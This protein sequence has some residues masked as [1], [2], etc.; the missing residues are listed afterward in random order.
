MKQKLILY[1]LLSVWMPV[2]LTGCFYEHPSLTEDGEWGT[3]PTAVTVMANFCLHLPM[4]AGTSETVFLPEET[5]GYRQ[6]VIVEAYLNRQLVA[7]EV[8]Y[9]AIDRNVSDVTIPV[10]MELH[11]RNYQLAVWVDYI[12]TDTVADLYYDTHTGGS[13]MHVIGNGSY[14]GNSA[15][16]DVFC[17]CQELDLTPYAEQ[18]NVSVPFD[19]TLAR[20]VARYELV[21]NDVAQFL[22]RIE[23]SEIP[24]DEFT[25]RLIYTGYVPTGYNV[26]DGLPRQ[27]LMYIEYDKTFRASDLETGTDYVLAFDYVFPPEGDKSL[28]ARLEIL[29][30]EE[31]IAATNFNLSLSP[32]EAKTLIHA[33]LTAS[34]DGG[35]V[36]DPDY[37]GEVDIDVP[38]IIDTV[39]DK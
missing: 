20:P 33:F 12:R 11:A 38:G 27:S 2:F 19:M 4:D 3:D 17:G 22:T 35:V 39:G 13:L 26:I 36:F 16:K 1:L 28:P 18:W 21:A 10:E 30:G 25:A 34:P 15:Y 9:A 31:V 7:Q 5:G 29:S 8:T 23:K 24:G 32:G 37:D 14:V 6:R